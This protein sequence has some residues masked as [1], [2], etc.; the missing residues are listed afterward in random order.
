MNKWENKKIDVN[1]NTNNINTNKNN[2]IIF[3][4]IKYNGEKQ[5][6]K[7]KL[8]TLPDAIPPYTLA[9]LGKKERYVASQMK[10]Y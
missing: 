10:L 3:I 2:N 1:N 6:E 7:R 8:C 9:P 5:W 4:I